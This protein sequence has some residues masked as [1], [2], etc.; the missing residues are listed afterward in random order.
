MVLPHKRSD[1]WM[2]K[3]CLPKIC[4]L[5]VQAGLYLYK[6]T[7]LNALQV[8]DCFFNGQIKEKYAMI[9]TQLDY[10]LALQLE[11]MERTADGTHSYGGAGR[12]GGGTDGSACSIS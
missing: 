3:L 8:L 11:L 5:Y 7:L 12:R 9:E 10:E 4:L 6:C 1:Y 2:K